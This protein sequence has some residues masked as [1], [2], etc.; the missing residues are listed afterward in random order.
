MPTTTAN[1]ASSAGV[2]GGN[3]GGRGTSKGATAVSHKSRVA[4]AVFAEPSGNGLA[5]SNGARVA[6]V[7]PPSRVAKPLAKDD[8]STNG[9]FRMGL[10]TRHQKQPK[11]TNY[12]FGYGPTGQTAAGSSGDGAI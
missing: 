9:G 4:A 2:S 10:Y 6:R 8:G 3:G 7:A 11:D 5:A 12:V 1:K